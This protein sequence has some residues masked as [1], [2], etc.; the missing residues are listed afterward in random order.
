MTGTIESDKK[1]MEAHT[2]AVRESSY[3]ENGEHWQCAHCGAI[4]ELFAAHRVC[5][6]CNYYICTSCGSSCS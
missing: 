4:L 6:T 2:A 1:V 3:R 5:P